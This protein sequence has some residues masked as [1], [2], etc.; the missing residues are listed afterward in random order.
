[1]YW[2]WN[3]IGKQGKSTE[4]EVEWNAF[5]ILRKNNTN[6]EIKIGQDK[7]QGHFIQLN[8]SG[9]HIC[10]VC[11]SGQTQRGVLWINALHKVYLCHI[12]I[13][14]PLKMLDCTCV[15]ILCAL[16]C[17]ALRL[18]IFNLVWSAQYLIPKQYLWLLSTP[19]S[20]EGHLCEWRLKKCTYFMFNA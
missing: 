5:H 13:T 16:F 19:L 18:N 11:I 6:I 8:M 7:G 17:S 2:N 9:R 10:I 15:V 4:I 1:M 14:W 20:G 3:N 12:C